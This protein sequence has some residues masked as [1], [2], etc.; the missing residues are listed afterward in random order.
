M[1]KK[2]LTLNIG[3]SAIALAEYETSGRSARLV[4][5][6]KAA[7]A[8][9]LDS[10]NA[11]TILVPALLEI[12]REKGIR[13]GKVAVALP[14]QMVFPRFAAIPMAGG[15]DKFDQLVRYEIEQ[16]VPFPIDEMVCDRQILGDTP[17]GDKSVMIVAAKVDQ[18][19]S[20]TGALSSAGFQPEIVGVSPFAVTNVF[21]TGGLDDGQCTILLDIGAKTTSLVIAEGEKLYNRSIPVAGNTVTKEIAQTLGCTLDEA[22]AYKCQHAYVSM[23]GVT[24]D[25]DETLDRVSKICRA[26]LTRLHAEVSRS[27]NFYRSQQGGGAPV[28]LLLTGGSSLMPQLAEFFQNSLGIEVSFLNPFDVISV[29]PQVDAGALESDAAFLAATAG[30]ALQ[31]AGAAPLNI[32]LIPQSILDAKAEL[33]R[34]PFVAIGA[35]AFVAAAAVWFVASLGAT[36]RVE[37]QLEPAGAK[38][39]EAQ[40]TKNACDNARKAQEDATADATRITRELARRDKALRHVQLVREALD[41]RLW[42]SGWTEF[43][44]RKTV[45]DAPARGSRKAKTHEEI[46]RITKVAFRCW[47]DDLEAVIQAERDR[48]QAAGDERMVPK[49]PLDIVKDRLNGTDLCICESDREAAQ[50]V[51]GP[52]DG[53]LLQF[54]VEI[55]FK[56]AEGQEEKAK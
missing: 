52:G 3:A 14:G 36:A 12:V 37:E 2:I 10:G 15:S 25:E 53:C 5:Y 4:N 29:G 13:P 18:V 1:A 54:Q 55:E 43:V 17:D 31:A 6:G 42:I 23:G 19:E 8:S 46:R 11:E 41:Q 44:E 27:I 16:N 47:K 21:R 30:L 56:E 50:R 45:E 7:L 39:A 9:P 49:S 38:A 35:I 24:E 22:D 40:A 33:A 32:N 26:V 48:R 28:R 34:I 20:I 51:F